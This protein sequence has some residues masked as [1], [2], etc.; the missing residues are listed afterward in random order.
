[1]NLLRFYLSRENN[2]LSIKG[3]WERVGKTKAIMVELKTEM[4]KDVKCAKTFVTDC[5][6]E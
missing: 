2:K 3:L 6:G 4:S 5:N 1:M